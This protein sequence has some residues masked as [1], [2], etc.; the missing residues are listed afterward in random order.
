MKNQSPKHILVQKDF[1]SISSHVGGGGLSLPYRVIQGY[2][3]LLFCDAG[4]FDVIAVG[5]SGNQLLPPRLVK[6]DAS[7]PPVFYWSR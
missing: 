7:L 6:E 1:L 4:V 2:S 5:R 3:H